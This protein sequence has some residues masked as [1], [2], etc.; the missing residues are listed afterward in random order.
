MPNTV[1][2]FQER[3]NSGQG[4]GIGL[5]G[6]R[7][8]LILGGFIAMA[9]TVI[10]W[11]L[12][13]TGGDDYFA[14]FFDSIPRSIALYR[15]AGE[16]SLPTTA[17]NAVFEFDN[18]WKTIVSLTHSYFYYIGWPLSA[19]YAWLGTW[20]LMVGGVIRLAA[21]S[22]VPWVR[23]HWIWAG[24]A[25]YFAMTLIWNVGTTNHGQALRHHIMTDWILLLVLASFSQ[26]CWH[27]TRSMQ[28]QRAG[29]KQKENQS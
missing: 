3:A 29:L 6:G 8:F 11:W 14:M 9:V 19:D 21:L 24:L 5:G 22:I 12:P 1:P 7:L 28:S 18:W 20:A 25:V 2:G 15:G 23:H 4:G 10:F 13:S 16:S 27:R 17:Y 26:L